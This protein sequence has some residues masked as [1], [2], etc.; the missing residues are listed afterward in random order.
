MKKYLKWI[1]IGFL[2]LV[3]IGIFLPKDETDANT[4]LDWKIEQ[5]KDDFGDA[6]GEVSL[7]HYSKGTVSGPY[8]DEPC[9]VKWSFKK[10]KIGSQDLYF[11]VTREGR[12]KPREFYSDESFICKIKYADGT[13]ETDYLSKSYPSEL[14][15]HEG[16]AKRIAEDLS[17][18]QEVQIIIEGAAYDY[19]M[20]L[21]EASGLNALVEEMEFNWSL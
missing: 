12:D 16:L 14:V 6:T 15:F 9:S 17:S 21:K 13:K 5:I 7:V 1:G 20:T 10:N 19:S 2:A 3:V 11:Q 4:G 8:D 18:G